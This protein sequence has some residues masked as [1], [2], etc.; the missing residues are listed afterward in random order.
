[1][2]LSTKSKADFS[3]VQHLC[4]VVVCLYFGC[5]SGWRILRDLSHYPL[6]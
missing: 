3:S 5:C 4:E 2:S 6:T 1:M